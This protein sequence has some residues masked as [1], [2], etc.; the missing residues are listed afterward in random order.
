VGKTTSAAATAVVAARRGV[1]TLVLSTDPAHSLADA[2][3]IRLGSE[4][5]EIEPGLHGQQVDTQRRFEESWETVRGYLRQLLSRGGVD[6]IAAEELTVLPGAQEVL[7]LLEVRAR[8]ADGDLDLVVVDCAPTAETVRLLALPQALRWYV[9]KVYPGHRRMLHLARP[10]LGRGAE[11]L[12]GEGV[13][14]AVERMYAELSEV[15][16]LLT[17][18]AC[19]SVRLVLTPESMVVAEA[20]RTF[21]SLSLY[22][23]QVDA[24]LA[25]RV[26]PSGGDDP[27]RASWVEAQSAQL[28]Q[29][30]RSFDP[31]PIRTVPYLSSEPVGVEALAEYGRQVY[32]DQDPLLSGPVL[33]ALRIE[34][35]GEA[36]RLC[37]PLPLADRAGLNLSRVGQ[38]LVITVGGH[39]RI[40]ALPESLWPRGI[41]GASLVNGELVIGFSEGRGESVT[42]AAVVGAV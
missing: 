38:E 32:G 11:A 25:N 29:V 16:D 36:L 1:R 2:F 4:P 3:G 33:A 37:V 21:T 20:R 34:P 22:G 10:F 23:F 28:E 5:T 27:W 7:A 8:A 24:V 19:T 14:A 26:I 18:P 42:E 41:A 13:L 39:R 15:H 35:E 30:R 6:G 17:D 40:I 12:P 9:D 31:L